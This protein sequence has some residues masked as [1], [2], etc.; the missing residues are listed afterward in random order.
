MLVAGV[1]TGILPMVHAHTFAVVLGT[2]FFLGLV[3][4]QWR[5]GRWRAWAVYV[6]ATLALAIP[7][8]VWTA[9]GSQAS[10]S[11]FFGLEIGWD[12]GDHD[13]LWFWL[14][15]TGVFIPLLVAAYAWQGRRPLPRKLLL[16][17]MPFLVWFVVPNFFRLAPW[18]W[19]NIKVLTYW[20]LGSVPI[21]ALVLA[22]LWASQRVARVGAVVLAIVLMGAGGLDIL[23]ASVGTAYQE[24][25][26]DGVAFAELIREQTPPT[27]VILTTPTYNTPVFLTGRRVFMGYAGFLWANGLPYV[28]REQDLRAIYAGEAGAE[29]LLAR[30]GISYIV[31]GPQERRE[32]A[33][34]DAFL[35]RFPVVIEVG[36]YRLLE[37]TQR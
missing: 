29:D 27:A 21:V 24:F 36:E 32:V 3:F 14:T 13:P 2:A 15:N 19:D 5:N 35:A 8:L 31:L 17:S 23:R 10:F 22:R 26:R 1:L 20:W 11:A 34:N 30:S 33:P 37:V 9:R 4:T 7:L 12:H 25:D 28:E 18:L 16:Y 6:V